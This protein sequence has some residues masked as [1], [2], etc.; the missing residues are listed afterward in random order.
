MDDTDGNAMTLNNKL[1]NWY[2]RHW[3]WVTLL[4]IV[5]LVAAIRIRLLHVPLERDEGEYAY[6]GQLILQGI[7][8]YAKVYNMKMP[9]IYAAY[10]VILAFFGQTHVA[11]HFGLLVVNAMTT[12]LLFLLGKKLFDTATGVV[13]AASF[14]VL[15]LSQSVQGVFANAEHFVILPAIGG[16]LLLVHAIESDRPKL[17]LWSGMLL[18]VAFIMKQHGAAF[19]AFGGLYLLSRE[20]GRRPVGWKRCLRRCG[21]FSLG[22]VVPFGVTCLTLLLVGVFD[23][24]WFWT[25]DYASKYVSSVPLATGLRMLR[26]RVLSMSGSSIPL[27]AL[28]AVGLTA[29]VWDKSARARSLFILTFPAFS[30]LSVCPGFYFR[31][32]YFILLLPAIALLVGISATS[33]GRLIPDRHPLYAR[34]AIPILLVLIAVLYSVFKQRAFLFQMSP[35]MASRTTYGANPFPES[36]EIAKYIRQHSS[37]NDTIAVIGSEPQIYFYSGRHSATGYIYTY[38]LMENHDYALK[39]QQ[40]M[41]DEIEAARPSFLVYVCVRTSWLVGPESKLL[42]FEW[43]KEHSEKNYELVGIVDILPSQG[44]SYYWDEEAA[45]YSPRSTSWLSIF[46]RRE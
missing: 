25:F 22:V 8:P 19:I 1:L 39:M 4:I 34:N 21:L 46:R 9:G 35:Y 7:P 16:I 28:A 13:T 6:A 27:W 17:L 10:A 23:R 44:A 12:V 26:Q 37:K 24:F 31:P 40:E 5:F 30:F 15:S 32:H 2:S 29:P 20:L 45:K 43:F 36:L 41:I 14:A 3:A 18:G 42:I 33:I 11:I 38:A